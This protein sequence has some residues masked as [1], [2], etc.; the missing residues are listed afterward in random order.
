ML[1]GKLTRQSV[2][3]NTTRNQ[4]ERVSKLL[5]L[6]ASE[7]EEVE[8][9]PFGSVGVILGLK[10][11]RTGDT[12]VS[13]GGPPSTRTFLPEIIPPAAVISASVIPQSH[14]DLGPV[15][16]AL[17]S[18]NRTDP[19]LRVDLQEGQILV[20]GMG[21][22]HLEI[23]EGRLRDEWNARFEIGKR[24]VT[25]REGLGPGEP[26]H[27]SNI[28][29]TDAGGKQFDISVTFD[30]RPL[31]EHENPDP[32][33]DGN[34][35]LDETGNPLPAPDS[36]IGTPLAFIGRGIASALSNSPNTSLAMSHVRIQLKGFLTPPSAALSSLTGASASILHNRLRDAGTGPVM[37]P[38]VHLKITIN[39]DSIG[40]VVKDL[41]EHGGEVLDL[42]TGP[43]T[44]EIG[45]YPDEGVYI[46]PSWLS[47]SGVSLGSGPN[48]PQIKRSIHALAPLAKML[49]YSNRLRALSGGHGNFEMLNAGF[50]GVSEVRKLEIL[51]E[52]GRA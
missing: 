4:R 9:L 46:P 12:L 17:A 38:Y 10:Y 30:V 22:L 19:S 36:M 50:K 51:K 18:L 32:T 48:L 5:L 45:G 39:E 41:T 3:L 28:W 25:Y 43:G 49:D 26:S 37:E 24:R 31:E 29:R 20:H 6:Y 40:K 47:P 2:V 1:T 44:D 34:L 14:S 7:A 27:N 21:A 8:E 35:V 15:Q 16:E 23:I 52:I 11:T 13:T 33:W 42:G